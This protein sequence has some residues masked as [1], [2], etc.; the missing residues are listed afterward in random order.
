MKIMDKL[1]DLFSYNKY[2]KMS[3][4]DLEKEARKYGIRTY[5][6]ERIEAH[7]YAM[8]AHLGEGEDIVKREKIIEQLIAK[9]NAAMF[10]RALVISLITLMIVFISLIV[11]IIAILR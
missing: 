2:Y 6:P 8:R 1:N 7:E 3:T 9:D 4:D 11:S 5:F 10:K